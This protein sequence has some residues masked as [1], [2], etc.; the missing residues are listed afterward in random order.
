MLPLVSAGE[1][2]CALANPRAFLVFTATATGGKRL[3]RLRGR[4]G[5]GQPF[6][7]LATIDRPYPGLAGQRYTRYTI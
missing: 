5:A 1:E 2:V 6:Q 7:V 4:L 3:R